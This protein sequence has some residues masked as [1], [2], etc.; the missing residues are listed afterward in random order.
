MLVTA[1]VFAAAGRLDL[2][3]LNLFL[4]PAAILGDA[5]GYTFGYHAG[6][7]LYQRQDSF[8]FRKKHLIAAREFYEK[9]GGAAIFL[10]RFVPFVRTFAPIV[11]GVAQ[12]PYRKFAGYNILGA[13]AWVVTGTLLGYLLGRMVPNIDQYLL[14]VVAVVVVITLIPLGYKWAKGRSG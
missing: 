9:H 3:L 1:G 6:K 7:G 10:A 4:I 11:A 12:M 8:F 13:A 5:T 14:V 2:L